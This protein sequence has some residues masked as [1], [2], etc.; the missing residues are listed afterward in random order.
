MK[1][2]IVGSAARNPAVRQYV[3]S[4][5]INDRVAIDAGCLGMHG[6]P[7][8][9]AAVDHVFLTHSHNDHC[10]SLPIFLENRYGLAPQCPVVYGSAHT[11]D[12][13]Q[14][15]LFNDVV[16]PDFIK[17]SAETRPFLRLQALEAEKPVEAAGLRIIPV[18]VHHAVP[19]LAYV[20][21]DGEATVI[22]AADSGPTDRLWELARELSSVSGVLLEASFPNSMQGLADVS[23][24]LTPQT[25]AAEVDKL[26]PSTRVMA[27]H[28]KV[29][30][31]EKVVQELSALGIPTLEIGECET[32][33]TF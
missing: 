21:I 8:D 13:L 6:S 12:S 2:R 9:Q 24:H 20:V 11:L 14:R 15:H 1:I 27:V 18:A 33:Y 4:Y 29:A 19:T 10:A 22:F 30:Y 25:F 26:P 7:Q 28:I 17:M 31:R 32:D 23:L 5:V 16:W 3:S